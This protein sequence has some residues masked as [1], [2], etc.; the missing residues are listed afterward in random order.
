VE[1][2]PSFVEATD[3]SEKKMLERIET[4][5]GRLGGKPCI[6]G[7]RISI[8]F[9][10]ELTASGGTTESIVAAHSFLA[11]EDVKQAVQ[12]AATMVKG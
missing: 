10:D 12:F 11:V 8:E 7:T 9:I 3:R 4:R 6:R 2:E 5:P 1:L